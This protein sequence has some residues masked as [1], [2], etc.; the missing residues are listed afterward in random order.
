MAVRFSEEGL[1]NLE[2][3]IEYVCQLFLQDLDAITEDINSF[4]GSTSMTGVTAESIKTYF[5][6][7][8]IALINMIKSY[9]EEYRTKKTAYIETLSQIDPKTNVVIDTDVLAQC[10]TDFESL[11][12]GFN[13]LLA[14]FG[15]IHRQIC[16]VMPVYTDYS[17]SGGGI[18]NDLFRS[19]FDFASNTVNLV[20]QDIEAFDLDEM[21]MRIAPLQAYRDTIK[22]LI[23]ELKDKNDSSITNYQ[24]GDILNVENFYE[25][26]MGYGVSQSYLDNVEDT[27]GDKLESDRVAFKEGKFNLIMNSIYY[28]YKAV[29]SAFSAAEN[30]AVGV[31]T[32]VFDPVGGSIKVV[33]GINDAFDALDSAYQSGSYLVAY[34]NDDIYHTPISIK[35][36]LGDHLTESFLG[37]YAENFENSGTVLSTSL[38][39]VDTYN[40]TGSAKWTFLYVTSDLTNEYIIVPAATEFTVNGIEYVTGE[41]ISNSV[42]ENIVSDLIGD[43]I[44]APMDS[45]NDKMSDETSRAE[46][47]QQYDETF[48][49]DTYKY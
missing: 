2:T 20:K 21:S 49:L 1:Y 34:G 16:H 38:K 46:L 37:D 12:T 6:E 3:D 48:N 22:T 40:S 10:V 45:I 32:F 19:R 25:A 33:N 42:Y 30:V 17:Y 43:T 9:I 35:G 18:A 15:D 7:T 23:A 14:T 44:S 28:G 11:K 41:E 24:T 13:S 8:H 26:A 5:K 29:S 36:E 47:M 31:S 4:V 39:I 27:V